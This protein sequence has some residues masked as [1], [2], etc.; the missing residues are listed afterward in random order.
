MAFCDVSPAYK[1][2]QDFTWFSFCAAEACNDQTNQLSVVTDRRR[3]PQDDGQSC[4]ALIN[5]NASPAILETLWLDT[6]S[7]ARLTICES[8]LYHQL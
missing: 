6:L 4:T 8:F 5:T 2:C 3:K 1:T 7:R